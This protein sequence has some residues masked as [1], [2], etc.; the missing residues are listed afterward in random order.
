[1]TQRKVIRICGLLA[2]LGGIIKIIADWL[3]IVGPFPGN[4]GFETMAAQTPFRLSLAGSLLGA[5]VGIPMW[6]FLLVPLYYALKPAGKGITI[7]VVLLL[8]YTF[9][10]SAVFH[11]AAGLFNAAYSALANVGA[12]SKPVIDEMI[13]HFDLYVARLPIFYGIG[14]GLGS[15]L[16]LVSILSG[17]TL[18]K[19]WMAV[20]SPLLAMA[21]MAVSNRLPAP[22]GGYFAPYDGSLM[23]TLFFLITTIAVWN[24]QEPGAENHM[25]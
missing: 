4:Y 5:A 24:Y 23:F 1:M 17:K 18:Y 7:P 25:M 11:S 10:L 9:V 14:L 13:A 16:L 21:I 22:I 8:G 2:I 6:L 15:L 12:E 20:F 3:L 19:R